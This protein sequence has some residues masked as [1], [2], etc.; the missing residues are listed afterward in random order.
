VPAELAQVGAW[1]KNVDFKLYNCEEGL[2][3]DSTGAQWIS[4]AQNPALVTHPYALED[5]SELPKVTGPHAE[6]GGGVL[7]GVYADV[8]TSLENARTSGRSAR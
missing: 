5:G 6:E 4:F 7:E 3:I 2:K 1:A 8:C